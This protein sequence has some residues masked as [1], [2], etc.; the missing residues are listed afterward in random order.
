MKIGIIVY[1][2]TGHTLAVAEKV[3]TKLEESGHEAA[4][5]QVTITGEAA[6]GKFQLAEAPAVDA[7]EGLIFGAPVHAFSL[8]AVMKTYLEQM[9]SLA[10]K[11]TALMITKQLPFA[12]TGGNRALGAMKTICEEK[13][14]Q[15]VGSAMAFWAASKQEK[16]VAACIDTLARCFQDIRDSSD[17]KG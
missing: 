8:S 4:V 16:S 5:V 7:Y 1:S 11:K 15:V 14:A 13:E 6:E 10:G 17:S 9:P 3:R 2:Q 12:W